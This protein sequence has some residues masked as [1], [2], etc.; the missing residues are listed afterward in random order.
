MF[1]CSY[2]NLVPKISVSIDFLGAEFSFRGYTGNLS[3]HGGCRPL[4]VWKWPKCVTP[5]TVRSLVRVRDCG[6][7]WVKW[8]RRKTRFLFVT[9]NYPT[10]LHSRQSSHC[11]W[12]G[13]FSKLELAHRNLKSMDG[14]KSRNSKYE[15]KRT[16]QI[17][18]YLL[19]IILWTLCYNRLENAF[20]SVTSNKYIFIYNSL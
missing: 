4:V 16:V 9:P 20:L 1:R 17:N 11:L 12:S 19:I 14:F 18:H 7:D 13:E 10:I 8:K 5:K 2:V 15:A 3:F 6:I